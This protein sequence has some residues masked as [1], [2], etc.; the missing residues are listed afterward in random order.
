M[1]TPPLRVW[2]QKIVTFTTK[3]PKIGY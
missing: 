1:S 3:G 2:G